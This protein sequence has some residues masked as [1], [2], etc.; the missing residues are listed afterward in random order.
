[1]SVGTIQRTLDTD[2][3]A[4]ARFTISDYDIEY[5]TDVQKKACNNTALVR[6]Q[7]TVH[8]I[9]RKFGSWAREA[10]VDAFCTHFAR[11]D[12]TSYQPA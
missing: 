5:M 6:W 8:V 9:S 7:V 1:M 12:V 3:E 4:R 10:T 2:P 11:H